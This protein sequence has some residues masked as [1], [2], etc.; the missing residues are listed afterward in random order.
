M[1]AATP[2]N[3]LNWNNTYLDQLQTLDP[4]SAEFQ[5]FTDV[6]ET[7]SQLLLEINTLEARVA[8]LE[9]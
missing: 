5:F 8:A 7:I 1:A 3:F 2:I 9:P 6:I 4:G